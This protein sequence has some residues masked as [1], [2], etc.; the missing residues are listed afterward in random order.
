M[1]WSAKA[2]HEDLAALGIR[3][4]AVD[5]AREPQTSSS[6]GGRGLAGDSA[7]SS[8]ETSADACLADP[9]ANLSSSDD[10]TDVHRHNLA[11][12]RPTIS[13]GLGVL[14]SKTIVT[15]RARRVIGEPRVP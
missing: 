7:L 6:P 11:V 13:V 12:R 9:L 10:I 5:G 1:P 8:T 3:C 15:S 2:A 4:R 14:G